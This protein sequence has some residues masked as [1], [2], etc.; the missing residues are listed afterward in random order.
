MGREL[1]EYR[2]RGRP[3]ETNSLVASPHRLPVPAQ[4]LVCLDFEEDGGDPDDSFT[5]ECVPGVMA[6]AHRVLEP[7]RLYQECCLA[8]GGGHREG[9]DGPVLCEEAR[10]WS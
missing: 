4:P 1:P 8:A 10:I 2:F 3:N 6:S 9:L 5:A 7:P